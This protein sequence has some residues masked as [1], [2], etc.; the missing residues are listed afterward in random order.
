M[1]GNASDVD[2][3]GPSWTQVDQGRP[4]WAQVDPCG[5]MSH[6]DLVGPRCPHPALKER[7][8][9]LELQTL[10]HTNNHFCEMESLIFQLNH[11]INQ[12]FTMHN[13]SYLLS[14]SYFS[15][16]IILF[17]KAQNFCQILPL[18]PKKRRN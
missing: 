17:K 1:A 15:K 5:P 7:I 4:K 2:P 10:L 16:I 11:P 6:V 14:N 18:K 12:V 8:G 13:Q 9:S 3:C